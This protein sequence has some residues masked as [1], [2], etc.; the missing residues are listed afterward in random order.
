MLPSSFWSQS[1]FPLSPSRC[2]LLHASH[3]LPCRPC[4][5]FGLSCFQMVSVHLPR[6]FGSKVRET[7]L[8]DP[9]ALKLREKSPSFYEIGLT[10]S[11]LVK[12]DDGA[13]LPTSTRVALATRMSSILDHSQHSLD[14]D[15]SGFTSTLTDLEQQLFDAGYR[16]AV[17]RQS[18]KDRSAFTIRP[19]FVVA[20]RA[21]PRH[22]KKRRRS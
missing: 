5:V 15:V 2:F 18:W 1:Y 14:Q 22:G 6:A 10:L 20:R 16:Y 13:T 17:D 8:A 4:L 21:R 19:S 7:L 9:T 11:R 12:H 3:S